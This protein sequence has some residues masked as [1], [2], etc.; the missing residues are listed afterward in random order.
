[1]SNFNFYFCNEPSFTHANTDRVRHLREKPQITN[2]IIQGY[3]SDVTS[4][5]CVRLRSFFNMTIG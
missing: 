2:R 1:M 5:L 4:S 3:I